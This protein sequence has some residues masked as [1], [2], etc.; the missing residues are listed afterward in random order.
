MQRHP[1]SNT[2]P[3]SPEG[4]DYSNLSTRE[5]SRFLRVARRLLPGVDK[6]E[7]QIAPYAASWHERNL[8]ALAGDEPLWVV[9]GDSISQ[10]IGATSIEH[11]WVLQAWRALA[12]QGLHYRV[13]NLSI[14]GATVTDVIDSEIPAMHGLGSTPAVVT[15]F[16]GSNDIVHHDLRAR[17]AT[18]YLRLIAA[19]PAGS[20]V[21][22]TG[23]DHGTL[24]E[25][26]R[27]VHAASA[28]GAVVGVPVRIA[29]GQRAEDHF[30]PND[31]AYALI[32]ADFTAAIAAM[33]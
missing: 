29:A 17:L 26:D 30:H 19:L 31:D 3:D 2:E 5:P 9:L 23:R 11:S 12:A 16:I 18:N 24:G 1:P 33:R 14:S 10:G 25:I 8:T 27:I 20:L 22:V 13:V 28:T 21:A 15:V 6:V 7:G 32:A 4:F